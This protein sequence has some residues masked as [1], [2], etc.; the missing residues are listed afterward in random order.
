MK[1]YKNTDGI[2]I[3]QK[4][5]GISVFSKTKNVNNSRGLHIQIRHNGDEATYKEAMK[6]QKIIEK[7]LNNKEV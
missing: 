3:Q 1:A 5:L 7:A 4:C 6:I 2:D